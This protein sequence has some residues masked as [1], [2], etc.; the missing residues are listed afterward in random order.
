MYP[1]GL[2]TGSTE[3][4]RLGIQLRYVEYVSFHSQSLVVQTECGCHKLYMN[5]SLLLFEFDFFSYKI[6]L[7]ISLTIK[8]IYI[9][10]KYAYAEKYYNRSKHCRII[11]HTFLIY[12]TH[13][14]KQMLYTR[15]LTDLRNLFVHYLGFLKQIT[16]SNFPHSLCIDQSL[17]EH[18]R[19]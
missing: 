3:K 5:Y 11:I 18:N 7:K 10:F 17:L 16:F 8:D 14:L 19:A 15:M 13:I 1:V 12:T 9:E 2:S 6:K 4:K